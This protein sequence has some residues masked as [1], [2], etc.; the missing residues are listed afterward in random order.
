MI[1]PNEKSINRTPASAPMRPTM[2][3]F[4]ADAC[5]AGISIEPKALPGGDG[6]DGD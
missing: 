6:D 1:T 3:S 2:S 4:I 5:G